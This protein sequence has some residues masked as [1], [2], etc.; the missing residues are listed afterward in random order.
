MNTAGS[1]LLGF[2]T[3]AATPDELASVWYTFVA[4]G[5]CG[6]LTTFSSFA[7]GGTVLLLER[8]HTALIL[9]IAANVGLSFA[10]ALLG[11]ALAS[12]S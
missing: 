7:Y 1:L 3:A 6:S 9:H 5:F 4:V 2:V 11:L 12:P 10:A 8:R